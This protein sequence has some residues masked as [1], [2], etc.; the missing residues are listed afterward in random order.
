MNRTYGASV[1]GKPHLVTI[2]TW[3]SDPNQ[4]VLTRCGRL[5]LREIPEP[6]PEHL[7][8]SCHRLLTRDLNQQAAD[9]R[10]RQRHVEPVCLRLAAEIQLRRLELLSG[11]DTTTRRVIPPTRTA[12]QAAIITGLL[13]A[14]SIALGTPGDYDAAEHYTH[15]TAA[16]ALKHTNPHPRPD[17][18]VAA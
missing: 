14:L 8:G 10:H 3:P 1:S 4:L 13:L 7:C 12:E 5:A 6:A 9:R 2:A 18:G 16:A 17:K 15:A 11:L